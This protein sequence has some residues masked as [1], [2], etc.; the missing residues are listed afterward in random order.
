MPVSITGPMRAH[1]GQ[2]RISSDGLPESQT[3]TGRLA[4]A[5]TLPHPSQN[6]PVVDGGQGNVD[7]AEEGAPAAVPVEGPSPKLMA[8]AGI[9][10]AAVVTIGTVVLLRGRST[11]VPVAE[12]FDAGVAGMPFC[13]KGMVRLAAADVTIGSDIGPSEEQPA[14]PAKGAAFC[15]DATVA[16]FKSCTDRKGCPG[17]HT[18]VDWAEITKEQ[19]ET[20]SVFCN[21]RSRTAP[22]IR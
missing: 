9:T 5:R 20:N 17:G 6:E 13:A 16:E 3:E 15:I 19:R 1:E 8:L 2:V 4:S 22:T 18:Q 7:C 11:P 14:H 21:G 10:I 12:P